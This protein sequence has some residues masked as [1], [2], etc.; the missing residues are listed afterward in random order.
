M[1]CGCNPR[2][3]PEFDPDCEGPSEEDLERFGGDTRPCPRCGSE[4]Y[5]EAPFCH[6]CG[7]GLEDA[8]RKGSKALVVGV[9][10]TLMVVLLLWGVL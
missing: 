7:V 4:I 2:S 1:P 5:D 8:P 6:R 9:M 3:G 10:V